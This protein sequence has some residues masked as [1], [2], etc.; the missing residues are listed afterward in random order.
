MNYK[1][2]MFILL[3]AFVFICA[4]RNFD[5]FMTHWKAKFLTKLLGERETARNFYMVL[6]VIIMVV[7]LLAT[8]KIIE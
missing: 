1:A 4:Y 6:G 3:G 8:L 7:G 5:W 2:I